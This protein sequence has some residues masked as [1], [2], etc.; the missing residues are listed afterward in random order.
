M[1]RETVDLSVLVDEVVRVLKES[2]PGRPVEV[3]VQPGLRASADPRLL[4]VALE[5]LLGNAWKFTSAND[6]AL[7]EF[8]VER[9]LASQENQPVYF[10]RD[11]GAGFDMAYADKL[12]GA[13]QRLHSP[14]EFEGTGVGLATVKRVMRRHGGD[15][16]ATSSVGEGATFFFTLDGGP[17]PKPEIAQREVEIA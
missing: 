6:A 5:N 16:W 2:E 15:V 10:V 1:R 8:G 3:I 11:N 9:D 14:E 7:I 12:F 13:F 4:R 17:R